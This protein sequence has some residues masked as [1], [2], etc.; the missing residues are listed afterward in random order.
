MIRAFTLVLA[1]LAALWPTVRRPPLRT[2]DQPFYLG[3]A[4]DLVHHGR[5]TDGYRFSAVQTD[6]L[7]AS[8]MRFAPLV[9]LTLAGEAE[10]DPTLRRNMDCL[11]L[12]RGHDRTCGAA[13]PLARLV[14]FAML[15]ATLWMVLPIALEA[16]LAPR[17]AAASLALAL[18]AAPTLLS[19]ATYLMTE[20][21][22]LL[23]TTAGAWAFVRAVR[24]GRR[25]DAALAGLLFG[26]AALC[27]PAFLYLP[28]L[29]ALLLLL[30]RATAGPRR[31]WQAG[32]LLAAASLAVAPWIARNAL[33]LGRPGLTFGYA[34]HTLAQR[35]SFDRMTWPDYALSFP[36]WLPDGN[37]L[38]KLIA[39]AGACARFGWDERSDTFYA[40]GM[41]RLVPALTEAA[42]GPDH[43]MHYLLV[44]ELW[45]HL[46]WHLATTLP[47]ALRG[48]WIAHWWGLALALATAAALVR[49]VR[50][51]DE[52]M[53]ALLLPPLAMLAL[54]AAVAVNQARYNLDL[55]PA[56]AVAGGTLA[57][58]AL[59]RLLP[60]TS[61]A[62]GRRSGPA[63]PPHRPD[64]SR[65]RSPD[66]PRARPP[67]ASSPF[68]RRDR[69]PRHRR[70]H[71]A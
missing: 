39:G 69:A 30:A 53:L 70:R 64:P 41:R 47:L 37:G 63:P 31:A 36:C 57:G 18:L 71:E 22:T 40:I 1:V 8:G 19:T 4:Y 43:L 59:T 38:G 58:R 54:N 62:S 2:F 68:P 15:A 60:R 10:L 65:S 3:I 66:L 16:G 50:R 44:H 46:G 29:L 28:A 67:E 27:R 48:L 32:L 23:F 9:P 52:P 5:F 17:A 12:G 24:R 49:A 6:G 55:V 21:P 26:L 34:G 42:G 61:S 33:V 14:Q 11:V 20:I 25:R 35:M 13:A 7:R 51:R 45:P 56:Y